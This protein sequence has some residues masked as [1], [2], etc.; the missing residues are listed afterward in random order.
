MK[1]LFSILLLL[2]F[3]S[4]IVN[5]QDQ[6]WIY[7][8]ATKDSRHYHD[9]NVRHT[10][11]GLLTTW[12]K[13]LYADD[14]YIFVLT[15]FDC[16]QGKIRFVSGKTYSA[17]GR[18]INSSDRAG[19]WLTATPES[20]AESALQSVCKASDTM[21]L[22]SSPVSSEN[23]GSRASKSTLQRMLSVTPPSINQ[24][25]NTATVNTKI[26]NPLYV[27]KENQ[28]YNVK[29]N[30]I[31]DKDAGVDIAR[32]IVQK[33]NLRSGANANTDIITELS[34]GNVLV[35]LSKESIGGWYNVIDIETSDEGWIQGNTIEVQFTS[36]RHISKP[37]LA[38][39]STERSDDNPY[40]VIKNDSENT[41]YLKLGA[42]RYV[43]EPNYSKRVDLIPG[44]YKFYAS[45]PKVLPDIGET[46]FGRGAYYTWRFFTRKVSRP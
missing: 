16:Q 39:T 2:F 34:K 1:T 6:R 18:L 35:L 19:N 28:I 31:I 43:I 36:E 21:N 22:A 15:E 46:T 24:N 45:S 5:A 13:W 44:S 30:Q 29:E 37:N 23:S 14:S 4:L 32:V 9:A 27:A 20:I 7:H 41:L 33:A 8:G 17:E 3:S 42:S 11:T 10:P 12:E 26:P 40:V 38:R 25:S